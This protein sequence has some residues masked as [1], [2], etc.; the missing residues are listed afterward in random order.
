MRLAQ[1][2]AP[3]GP[4][5]IFLLA[6]WVF[7]SKNTFYRFVSYF[8][9]SRVSAHKEDTKAILLKTALVRVSFIQKH[10][11]YRENNSKSVRESRYV[12]D[13]STP[14]KLSYCLPLSNS[15]QLTAIKELLRTHLL[16]KMYINS[17]HD[18][19]LR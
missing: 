11:R 9:E 3:C 16:H 18:Q 19:V 14:P 13:V 15:V 12:L 6:P 7:W 10:T 2:W 5:A 4:S 8:P 17:V 1:V